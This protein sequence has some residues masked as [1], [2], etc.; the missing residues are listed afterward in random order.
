MSMLIRNRYQ[1]IRDLPGGGFGQTFL[2]KDID[3]F[4]RMCVIKQ[5]KP[6]NEK[7]QLYQLI[8]ERF[9]REAKVL[10]ELGRSNKQIPELYAYF[11]ESGLFYLV[12][13][14]VEGQTLEEKLLTEGSLSEETVKF[15]LCSILRILQDIHSRG[16]I[17][18]D[19]KPSNLI[20]RMADGLPVL[21]DF[22]AVKEMVGAQLN[23]T[24]EPTSQSIVVGTQG[25][26]PLEQLAGCPVYG[27]D[28]YGLGITAIHA[29]T[30]QRPQEWTNDLHTG[31]RLWHRLAPQVSSEF[32]TILDK[33]IQT[34]SGDRYPTAESM[35]KAVENAAA[36]SPTVVKPLV[37]FQA[38]VQPQPTIVSQPLPTSISTQPPARKW[39]TGKIVGGCILAL[40]SLSVGYFYLRQHAQDELQKIKNAK[41]QSDHQTCITLSQNFT[42][43]YSQLFADQSAEAK[44]AGEDCSQAIALQKQTP[45]QKQKTLQEQAEALKQQAASLQ[46][47]LRVD[48]P[49][50]LRQKKQ[51]LTAKNI[52]DVKPSITLQPDQ[53]AIVYDTS[54]RSDL[55]TDEKMKAFAISFMKALRGSEDLGFPEKYT[56]FSQLTVSPSTSHKKAVITT[57]QWKA[58][59]ASKNKT[60]SLNKLFAQIQISSR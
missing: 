41:Q 46:N 44:K 42:R 18:R 11:T 50:R 57:E 29:L 25:Y 13:E 1:V 21:I 19:I 39:L 45:L 8:Q 2:A 14:W 59:S 35:L 9:E 56:K 47:Y 54:T 17:H 23:S 52:D 53:V 43:S 55:A 32:A 20:I 10:Q 6:I 7:P 48:V 3:L 31:H 40:F 60:A 36:L 16:I 27:S 15:L 5:L 26:M 28:L 4:G 12:Q 38:L 30:G 33:S 34:N 24:G 22:G 58:F 51:P 37:P 49:Q